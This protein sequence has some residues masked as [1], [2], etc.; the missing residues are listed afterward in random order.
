MIEVKLSPEEAAVLKEVLNG[1]L[2]DLR[3]EISATDLMDFREKLR[4][5]EDVLNKVVAQLP[6]SSDGES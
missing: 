6:E 1:Y 4:H 5:Q 3:M 2:S